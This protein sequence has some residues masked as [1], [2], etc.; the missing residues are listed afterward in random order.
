[1]IFPAYKVSTISIHVPRE[2]HDRLIADEVNA[3]N[4][5]SIH[6]PREGHDFPQCTL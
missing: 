1:M 2:G 5:I 3:N 6:V 4:F